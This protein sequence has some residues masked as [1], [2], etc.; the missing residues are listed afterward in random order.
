M[1]HILEARNWSYTIRRKEILHDVTLSIPTGR[2]T[3]LIG[4][5]GSGKTTFI[6][7][8]LGL[9]SR[10]GCTKESQLDVLGLDPYRQGA[11]VRREVGFVPDRLQTP[12]WMTVRDHLRLLS[13]LFPTW[14]ETRA[15]ELRERFEIDEAQAVQS[16]SKGQRAAHAIV[17]ALAHEPKLLVLDEPFDGLDPAARRRVFQAVLEHYAEGENSVLFS[18]QSMAEVERLADHV[19]FLENG[20]VVL[21]ESLDELMQ[22]SARVAV[23]LEPEA[24]HWTPP[25]DPLIEG[26]DGTVEL[27]YLTWDEGIES[28]LNSDSAVRGIR[29]LPRKLEE[30]FVATAGKEDSQ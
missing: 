10:T 16:L 3:A 22:R 13:D 1:K 14:N 19:L 25:G 11:R 29:R 4:P 27:T 24:V 17:C 7:G 20:Q 15:N 18:T 23:E 21:D 12:A 28:E 26:A 9:L 2:I 30:V 8:V 5:N 6:R